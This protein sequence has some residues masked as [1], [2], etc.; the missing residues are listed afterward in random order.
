VL[1]DIFHFCRIIEHP[2]RVKWKWDR[3]AQVCQRWRQIVLTSPQHLQ[4]QLLCAPGTPVRTH[5]S[6]WPAFPIIVNY[7]SENLAPSD[8]DNVLAA[9]EHPDRVYTLDLTLKASQLAKLVAVMQEPHPIL[10]CL[11]LTFGRDAPVLPGGFLGGS[12][13]CLQKLELD[14]VP[15]PTLP[16]LLASAKDLRELH[17]YNIPKSGY[18]SPEA[19]VAGLAASTSLWSFYIGFKSKN[20]RPTQNSLRPVT[21][22]VLPAIA[23]IEFEGVS[24]YLEDLVARIDCPK[25][26]W[27]KIW[28]LYRR[29]NFRAVHLLEFIDRSENYWVRQ[30]RRSNV[31][32]FPTGEICLE[33]AHLR[34]MVST[35]I[36][37][38][39]KNWGVSHLVQMFRQF[40]TKLSEVR[41]LYIAYDRPGAGMGQNEWALL[42][43][44]F[45]AVRTL[46]V[47]RGWIRNNP[48]AVE[49]VTAYI[50]TGADPEMLPALGLLYLDCK[51]QATFFENV[52]AE[53]QLSNRPI[54]VVR[55]ERE[56]EE[57]FQSYRTEEDKDPSRFLDILLG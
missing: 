55:C 6:C 29:A 42:F 43:R 5:L 34:N 51:P 41:Y 40:S 10:Q 31:H 9:L 32:F 1:L 8:E 13:P 11:G 30:F 52:V 18:I 2:L 53:R 25:L 35:W 4:I 12:A 27:I 15:F 17:L 57:S 14:A 47:C 50:A 3:L 23:T 20:S 54:T 46:H 45:T 16:S 37:F 56:F 38:Q 48:P 22:V 44:P 28:Y 39:G 7:G 33:F 36:T 19:L 49:G 21:R 24:D 26:Q